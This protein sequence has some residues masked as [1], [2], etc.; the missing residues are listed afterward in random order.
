MTSKEILQKFIDEL[1]IHFPPAVDEETA[2]TL[3]T[4]QIAE[5]I[6][7]VFP[8]EIDLKELYAVL[9]ENGYIFKAVEENSSFNFLWLLQDAA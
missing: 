2:I 8:G 5:K 3:S 6:N 1:M 7:S 9:L 4:L